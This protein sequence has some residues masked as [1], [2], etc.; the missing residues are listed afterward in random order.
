MP[1]PPCV[2]LLAGLQSLVD[3]NR[4]EHANEPE[5]I[6]ADQ[7]AARVAARAAEVGLCEVPG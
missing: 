1:S 5:A 4:V 2:L 7:E 3:H 6:A